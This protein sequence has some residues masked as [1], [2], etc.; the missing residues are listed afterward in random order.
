MLKTPILSFI[1]MHVARAGPINDYHW[2]LHRLS[3]CKLS[4]AL[5]IDTLEQDF[6]VN[7]QFNINMS[8]D[9]RISDVI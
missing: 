4:R 2:L 8:A 6:G 5:W 3:P 1:R 9:T 7:Y